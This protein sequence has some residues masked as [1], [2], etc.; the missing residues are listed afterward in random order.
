MSTAAVRPFLCIQLAITMVA[1]PQSSKAQLPD[2]VFDCHDYH[3]M[4][5]ECKRLAS[6]RNTELVTIG[7]STN[8]TVSPPESYPI[9]AL[10]LTTTRRPSSS[11]RSF[12]RPAIVFDGGI[13][14]RER[15]ASEA[16]VEL[17]RFLVPESQKTDSQTAEALRH[18]DVWIIPMTNPAGRVLDDRNGGDPRNY[19]K[20]GPEA[21]GWRGNGDTRHSRYAVDLARNFSH[22]WGS[23]NG[24]PELKHWR[25]FAPFS[26][27]ESTAIRQFIQNHL[28]SMAV[29]VHSNTQDIVSAADRNDLSAIAMRRKAAEVWLTGC[30]R[31]AN[32]LQRRAD[33]LKLGLDEQWA[34]TSRGQYAAWLMDVS[35]TPNQPDLGTYRGIQ[36]IGIEMP[37]DNPKN[38]NYYNGLFQFEPRDGSSSFHPSGAR[39]R[40][41]L[42]EAWIPMALYLIEQAAAP[43]AATMTTASESGRHEPNGHCRNDIGIMAARIRQR[44][45]TAGSLTSYPAMRSESGNE[46]AI[47]PAFDAI[48]VGEHFLD[49]FIQNYSTTNNRCVVTA[50][51]ESRQ[52]DA[53]ADWTTALKKSRSVTS[54]EP[55]ERLPGRFSFRVIAGREYRIRLEVAARQDGLSMNDWKA[56]RFLGMR[57]LPKR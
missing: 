38:G 26:G 46:I 55:L 2:G 41:L 4:V 31:L 40:A 12:G 30:G 24:D 56:F 5:A 50:H 17:A 25:G 20:D 23:A 15:I 54:I 11:E 48:P 28:I 3:E 13:H 16:M 57:Q 29:H 35:D 49:Y 14:P 52:Q 7:Q 36:T 6:A 51:V 21:G 42:Q 44:S 37:F 34:S 39:T 19:Y 9:V 33:E 22:D 53:D 47:Q 1:A 18:I 43:F 32:R 8:F 45:S 27:V 10:H